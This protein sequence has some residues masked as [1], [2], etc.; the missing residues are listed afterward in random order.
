MP[1][2]IVSEARLRE[3]CQRLFR[4]GGLSDDHAVRATQSLVWAE[5]RGV[6]THGVYWVPA[7]L[8]RLRG[9]GA[10]ATPDIRPITSAGALEH[11]DGDDGLGIVVGSLAMDRAIEIAKERGLGCVTV[12]RSNHFCAGG[13]YPGQAVN[14]GMI[15]IAMSN[16]SPGVAIHGS[17]G[18]VVGNNPIGIGVPAREFP[19]ILDMSAGISS[20]MRIGAM[21]RAGIPVPEDWFI[22]SGE[23][24][25]RPAL[26]P[27]GAQDGAGAKGSGIAI[28]IEALTGVLAVGG[29]LSNLSAGVG[30]SPD[31]SDRSC[32]TMIAVDPDSLLPGGAFTERMDQMVRE[33][34][35]TPRAEGVAEICMPGERAW[36]E[37][38]H[39]ASAGIPIPAEVA[40]QIEDVAQELGVTVAW[41]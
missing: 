14:R 8:R 40:G 5:L 27:M 41:D 10:N 37:S 30:Y 3:I 26:V 16:S 25:G 17:N 11:W 31:V 4:A 19:V 9:P 32:H 1:D 28:M 33:L 39:R 22:A 13:A 36:R 29:M 20:G 34:K 12:R 35:D 23:P 21:R 15:G 6:S 18:R 2:I 38:Q 24:G 7:S